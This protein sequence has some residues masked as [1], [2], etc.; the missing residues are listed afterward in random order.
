MVRFS[1]LGSLV[2]ICAGCTAGT[3]EPR[4]TLGPDPTMNAWTPVTVPT[5][6]KAEADAKGAEECL[7]SPHV[8]AL[9]ECS[10]SA[11]SQ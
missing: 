6:A 5:S 2:L 3:G 11:A 7:S 10:K 4:A 1:L 8:I 9:W